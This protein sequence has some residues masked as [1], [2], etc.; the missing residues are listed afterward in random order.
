M[1][2]QLPDFPDTITDPSIK[3][4]LEKY[5]EISNHPGA[6][7]DYADLFTV[8]GIWAHVPDRE[9]T[10]LQ[11]Y[12]HGSNAMEMVVYGDV[13]YEHH[14]GHKTG[15]DWAAKIKLAKEGG[16][17]KMAYYQIIVGSADLTNLTVKSRS[18]GL[19]QQ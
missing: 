15:T 5:Y 13:K 2:Y 16:E 17:M 7:D 6:H 1:R 19:E 11:I 10:P 14:A 18:I 8:D 3:E 9:H 12:T 4:F